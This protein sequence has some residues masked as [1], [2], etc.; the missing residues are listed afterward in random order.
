MTAR[1]VVR[2]FMRFKDATPLIE[3]N[4]CLQHRTAFLAKVRL[5]GQ[6]GS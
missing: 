6:V 1:S 2:G 5:C 3:R 4:G